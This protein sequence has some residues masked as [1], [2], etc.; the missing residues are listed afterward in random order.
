MVFMDLKTKIIKTLVHPKFIYKSNDMP[1]KIPA[2]SSQ[3]R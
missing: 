2:K 1:I 3:Y